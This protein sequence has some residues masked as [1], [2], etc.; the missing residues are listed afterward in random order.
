MND[1]STNDKTG[2]ILIVDDTPANLDILSEMLRLRGYTIRPVTS[3]RQAL[4]TAM[5]SPPDIILLDINMPKMNGYEVC[6]LLKSNV[7]LNKIPVIFISAL[8]ETIDRVK[9]FSVGGVDYI[10]KPFQY[11]EVLARVD[12]HLKISNLQCELEKHNL[13]LEELVKEKIKELYESQMATILALSELAESRDDDTG[14]HLD[15]VQIYCKRLAMELSK[16]D[17]YRDIINKSYI[18]NIFFA[19]PMHD[20]GKV[21]IP[22][23]ILLKP[24]KLT[25]DEFEIMKTHTTLGANTLENVRKKYPVNAFINMGI[26]IAHYHHER[27]DGSGYPEG[28]SGEEIPLSARIMSIADVYDA[29]RSKRSYKEPFSHD[30]SCDIIMKGSGTQFDPVIIEAFKELQDAFKSESEKHSG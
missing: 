21:A 25:F 14:K 2:N 29:L 24:G 23:S 1:L 26:G 19:S 17:N 5:I 30:D 11:E 16:N 7:K 8:N 18:D 20:I 4:D 27:W 12:A 22:D 15:R 9:A 6:E 10:T 3:G 13:N 28:L